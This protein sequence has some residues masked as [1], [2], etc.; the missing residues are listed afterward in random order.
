MVYLG[1]IVSVFI[2][3]TLLVLFFLYIGNVMFK[4]Y[5]FANN[6]LPFLFLHS[7][8]TIMILSW[9]LIVMNNGFDIEFSIKID[10]TILL[11]LIVPIFIF[12][13]L[14]DRSVRKNIYGKAQLF[15]KMYRWLL[16][17]LTLLLFVIASVI[18]YFNCHYYLYLITW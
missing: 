17:T 7:L 15:S 10:Y 8:F 11:F 5:S 9:S 3:L 18:L 1:I 16:P 2:F 6:L 13:E 4:K 12:V 14:Y